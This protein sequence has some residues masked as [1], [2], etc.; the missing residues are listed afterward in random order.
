MMKTIDK[1]GPQDEKALSDC[2]SKIAKLV[3]EGLDPNDAICKVAT[4]SQLPAGQVTLAATA[5]NTGR[6]LSQLRSGETLHDKAAEFPLAD[7][8][9][10]LDRLYPDQIKT[11]NQ[12]HNEQAISSDYDLPPSYWLQRR[13]LAEKRAAAATVKLPPMTDKKAEAYPRL[14]DPHSRQALGDVRRI[15]RA[16]EEKKL[17]TV[18]LS[19]KA[20]AVMDKLAN[21]FRAPGSLPWSA[22]RENVEAA[23]GQRG[24]KLLDKVASQYKLAKVASSPLAHCVDWT[25][26]PYSLVADCLQTANQFVECRQQYQQMEKD[27]AASAEETLRPFSQTPGT[28]VITGSAWGDPSSTEKQAKLPIAPLATGAAIHSATRG[29][30]DKLA[31]ASEYDLIAKQMR[32]LSEPAHET[33]LKTIRTQAMLHDLM[34]NDPVISGYEPDQVV[35]AFNQVNQL[36]PQAMQQR[37]VA[38]TLMRKFLEQDSNVDLFEQDSLLGMEGKLQQQLQQFQQPMTA[39]PGGG[40]GAQAPKPATGNLL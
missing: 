10:I 15:K 9:T 34:A 38:Q 35:N 2:L 28:A 33:K 32:E 19:Y 27:A 39:G 31:P 21:Y 13:E 24:A 40:G 4:E 12:R 36:A 22:V 18:G 11:A 1:L 25:R 16:V 20:I 37:M 14:Q 3:N 17:E 5:Y 8:H 7:P 30:A 6:S 23:R 29:L 26:A